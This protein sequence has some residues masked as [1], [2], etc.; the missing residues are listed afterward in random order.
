MKPAVK[1]GTNVLAAIG[2]ELRLM[3]SEIVAEG[4]REHYAQILRRLDE[5]TDEISKIELTP[6]S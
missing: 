1:L 5:P 6:R 2:H 3:Y 4:V